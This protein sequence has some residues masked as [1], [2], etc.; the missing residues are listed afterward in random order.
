VPS[1]RLRGQGPCRWRGRPLP[2]RRGQS[3]R[4]GHSAL[5]APAPWAR[6]PKYGRRFGSPAWWTPLNS[7]ARGWRSRWRVATSAQASEWL[8]RMPA[9]CSPAPRSF[10]QP[11]FLGQKCRAQPEPLLYRPLSVTGASVTTSTALRALPVHRSAHAQRSP[12]ARNLAKRTHLSRDEFLSEPA[13]CRGPVGHDET[14]SVD[15]LPNR[16]RCDRCALGKYARDATHLERNRVKWRLA[17]RN[18]L[19]GN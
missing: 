2:C 1:A 14:N 11:A 9:A 3:G 4:R 6:Q 12:D 8:Q 15:G 5:T 17:H 16:V 10:S 13:W 19:M 18:Q 7:Q